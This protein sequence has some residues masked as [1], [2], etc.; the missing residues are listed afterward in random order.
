MSDAAV[1]AGYQAYREALRRRVCAICL[2]G[3][4]D[5]RCGLAPDEPCPVEE[6]LVALVDLLVGMRNRR[7]TQCAAAVEA[8]ICSRCT[9]REPSGRCARRDDG[10]CALAVFLP[11]IVEAIGEVEATSGRRTA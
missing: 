6:H 5:G 8:Q 10:R 11:L 1:R 4:D 3:A 9:R 7:D 2:D